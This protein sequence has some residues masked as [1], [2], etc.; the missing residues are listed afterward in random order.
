MNELLEYR[1]FGRHRK[2]DFRPEYK[3]A[4]RD[5]ILNLA[6]IWVTVPVP[7]R[8]GS[9]RIAT[10]SSQLIVASVESD[11]PE[12]QKT[13]PN[14]EVPGSSVPYS[15]AIMLGT[16]AT[17]YVEKQ[18]ARLILANI[19]AY[20]PKNAEE[21]IAMRLGLHLHFR[22]AQIVTV[23]EILEGAR[24][25]TPTHHLERFRDSVENALDR[26]KDDGIIGGWA[27]LEETPLPR[28]RWSE[29]WLSWQVAIKPSSFALKTAAPST[30]LQR[31][32][33]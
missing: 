15:F 16:W 25:D 4:E 9:K 31:V 27:Y 23:R 8:K 19:M 11:V 13:L 12:P 28:Y 26:L 7:S 24:I 2:R 22:P 18:E 33:T 3:I 32:A 1:G 10:Q 30:D 20:D 29:A 6:R 14:L 17:S 5:R 21:R